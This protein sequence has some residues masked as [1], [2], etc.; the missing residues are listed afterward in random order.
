M[1]SISLLNC[2]LKLWIAFLSLAVQC[3]YSQKYTEPDQVKQFNITVNHDD[4]T[5]KTQMLKNNKSISVN[6][7]LTYMWY[8]SQKIMETKG[9]YE[10]KLIHG[11]YTAFYLNNQLKEQG[12]VK[13]GLKSKE[14]K[15]WYPDGK[16]KEVITWKNGL[17]NGTYYLYN[18]YG[19]L[20]AKSNFKNDKLNGKFYTYGNNGVVLEKKKY[21]NGEEIVPVPKVEKVK[22]EKAP[23]EKKVKEEKPKEEKKT[24]KTKEEKTTPKEE[25]P[26]KVKKEKK[27]D[28]KT[29]T[30]KSDAKVITS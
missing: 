7:E 18:D 13:Y 10:G 25:K 14:W 15:Y 21:K 8:A 12:K 26:K 24:K 3:S 29:E 9:G 6:N 16:L 4:Y 19:Q 5:V 22:K 1:K 23:K 17:K 2:K 20:M 11:K 28:K 30:P 27:S